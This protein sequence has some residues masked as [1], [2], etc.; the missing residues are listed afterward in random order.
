MKET[1]E[2]ILRKIITY[3]KSDLVRRIKKEDLEKYIEYFI[4][5]SISEFEIISKIPLVIKGIYNAQC[6]DTETLKFEL[7][8]KN[9][10][11]YD[12][13]GHNGEWV[14]KELESKEEIE[15]YIL[16]PVGILNMFTTSI[17]VIYE[18]NI[19]SYKV[20]DKCT[21]TPINIKLYEDIDESDVYIKWQ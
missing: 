8:Y 7:D 5:K 12:L 14:I 2:N 11:V 3:N 17:V 21:N 10:L 1:L 18:G 15:K 9:F 20:M 4:E 16:G 13:I 19:I 6:N